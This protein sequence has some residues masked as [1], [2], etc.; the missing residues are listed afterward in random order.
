MS[1]A[2]SLS[3]FKELGKIACQILGAPFDMLDDPGV[4]SK[5]LCAHF[6]EEPL[7]DCCHHYTAFLVHEQLVN[8]EAS[9]YKMVSLTVPLVIFYQLWSPMCYTSTLLF[10]NDLHHLQLCLDHLLKL[11]TA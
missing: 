7:S 10:F 1:V 4:F 3:H 9:F 11:T 2:I 5:C 8:W 6:V